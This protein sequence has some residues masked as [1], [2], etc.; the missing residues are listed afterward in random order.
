M[1]LAGLSDFAPAAGQAVHPAALL[2]ARLAP[3][4]ILSPSGQRL[5]LIAEAFDVVERSRLLAA[6]RLTLP[7]FARAQTLLCLVHL[8]AQLVETFADAVFRSVGVGI[9]SPAQPVGSPLHPVGQVS[10][11]HAPQGVAQL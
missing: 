1:L 5:N 8:L 11:V 2:L 7:G 3:Q 9:D 6:L 4:W 10:L